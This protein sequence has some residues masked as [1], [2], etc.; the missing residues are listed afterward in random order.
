MHIGNVGKKRTKPTISKQDATTITETIT[1]MEVDQETIDIQ[2]QIAIDAMMNMTNDS[3]HQLEIINKVLSSANKENEQD[4][5]D[6]AIRV[7][8]NDHKEICFNNAEQLHNATGPAITFK[9]DS[10]QFWLNGRR[11]SAYD[12]LGD[13]PE[14][15]IETLKT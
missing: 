2:T 11:V 13:T 10:K 3:D 1:Q 14:A 6:V 9:D 7:A 4:T 8:M 5:R 12:V 15:F